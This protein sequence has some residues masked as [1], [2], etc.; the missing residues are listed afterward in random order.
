MNHKPEPYFVTQLDSRKVTGDSDFL[1]HNP[2]GCFD[3]RF[4][5]LARSTDQ[6]YKA[7]HD[8]LFRHWNK[9]IEFEGREEYLAQITRM[10]NTM[11]ELVVDTGRLV[12]SLATLE[13]EHIAKVCTPFFS[14]FERIEDPEEISCLNLAERNLAYLKTLPEGDDRR[15]YI[16]MLTRALRQRLIFNIKDLSSLRT[17]NAAIEMACVSYETAQH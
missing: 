4:Y 3:T 7:A 9:K 10:H 13:F 15:Y 14:L 5:T 16:G 17:T 12:P 1:I 6:V 11:K 2:N 8:F